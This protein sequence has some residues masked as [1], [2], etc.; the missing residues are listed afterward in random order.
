MLARGEKNK[1]TYAPKRFILC[2]KMQMNNSSTFGIMNFNRGKSGIDVKKSSWAKV[3]PASIILRGS[4]GTLCLPLTPN[5][6]I[7]TDRERQRERG[8]SAE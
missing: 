5:V 8:G 7:H 1:G 3:T 2:R 4:T 6:H